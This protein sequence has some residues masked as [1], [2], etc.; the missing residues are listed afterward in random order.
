MPFLVEFLFLFLFVLEGLKPL[1]V[2]PFSRLIYSQAARLTNKKPAFI[3]A[4]ILQPHFIAPLH[5]PPGVPPEQ[6]LPKLGHGPGNDR[7]FDHLLGH[8]LIEIKIDAHTEP[9]DPPELEIG[10]HT[11]LQHQGEFRGH[12]VVR[13]PGR[14][15]YIEQVWDQLDWRLFAA[16]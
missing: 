12:R 1:A 2:Q 9:L 10:E 13:L 6:N 7:E 14:L 4:E 16:D 8:N 15:P 3:L 5:Q 11:F